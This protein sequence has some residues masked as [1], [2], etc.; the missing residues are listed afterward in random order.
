MRPCRGKSFCCFAL[1]S[2]C[3]P[4]N[5]PKLQWHPQ[6]QWGWRWVNPLTW[7]ARQLESRDLLSPGTGWTTTARQYWEAPCPWSPTLS[8]RFIHPLCM[9]VFM[10]YCRHLKVYHCS[11]FCFFLFFYQIL[12]AR[13][14]DSGTYICTAQNNQGRSETRVEVIIE[15][16]PQ[17]PTVPRAIVREPLVVVV[18][19][20]TT[21]LHCDAHGKYGSSTISIIWLKWRFTSLHE[22]WQLTTNMSAARSAISFKSNWPDLIWPESIYAAR[23]V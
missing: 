7:S 19:G 9:L 22:C 2:L 13:P 18:E 20:T 8:C 15:G 14:E 21:V 12:V 5:S 1:W 4:Q 23:N 17:V 6:G 10:P 11:C 3:F 16:G